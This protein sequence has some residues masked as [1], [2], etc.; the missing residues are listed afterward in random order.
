MIE[1]V[2]LRALSASSVF[3]SATH[4]QNISFTYLSLVFVLWQQINW[5]C[6][7]LSNSTSLPGNI[8][9]FYCVPVP[10]SLYLYLYL[11]SS[12]VVWWQSVN[13]HCFIFPTTTAWKQYMYD[14]SRKWRQI[15][16]DCFPSFC[17]CLVTVNKLLPVSRLYKFISVGK[18]SARW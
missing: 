6:F 1:L 12:V 15:Y 13:G 10:V 14:A 5:H 17:V 11:C 2:K 18:V 3:K 4:P 9:C 16:L 8:W 7:I